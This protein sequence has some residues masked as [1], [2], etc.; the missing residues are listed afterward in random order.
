MHTFQRRT[1]RSRSHRH[2]LPQQ[3]RKRLPLLFS[4]RFHPPPQRPLAAPHRRHGRRP[5]KPVTRSLRHQA[6]APT[7]NVDDQLHGPRRPLPRD[8]LR[9]RQPHPSRR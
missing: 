6:A 7:E 8:A 2:I 9:H 1:P 3:Y 5:F 4:A